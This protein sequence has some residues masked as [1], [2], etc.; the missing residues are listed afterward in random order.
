MFKKD[1]IFVFTNGVLGLGGVL[2]VVCAVNCLPIHV[3]QQIQVQVREGQARL[4][5]KS[6]PI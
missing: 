3:V 4:S 1:D 2:P 5:R 6:A